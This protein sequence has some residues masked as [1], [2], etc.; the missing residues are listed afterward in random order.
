MKLNVVLAAF[1]ST[2]VVPVAA[3]TARRNS[4][5]VGKERPVMKVVRMLQDMN[6]ELT[7]AK[8][9]DD[10]V[11]QELTCWCNGGTAEKQ[12]AIELGEAKMDDLKAAM[13]EYGAKI[14]E[15]REGLATVKAKLREDKAAL[16]TATAI[17]MKE[18]KA[19]H[20]EE[21]DML[22]AIQSCG[23]ALVVLGKHHSLAQ[24][25]DVGKNL[26]ALTAMQLAK[27]NLGRDKMAVLKAFLQEAEDSSTG[28]LRRIPGMQSYTPASGQIVG[29]LKQMKEDFEADLSSSQK[30]EATSQSEFAQLKVAKQEELAAGKAQQ[31]QL[32]QDDAEFREKNAQA[33]EEYGDTE[34]QVATDKEF[35][36]NL[37][38]RCASADADYAARTKGRLA[39][40][41]AV[42]D[43][44]AFLN[45][46]EA[47]GSFDKTVNSAFLQTSSLTVSAKNLLEARRHAAQVLRRS[48]NAQLA[49]LASSVQIDAFEKVKVAI[50]NMVKELGKQQKEEVEHR[51]FC[52]KEMNTNTRE[53]AAMYDKKAVLETTIAD[54]TKTV[55]ELAKDIEERT[56]AIATMQADMKRSSE[57]RESENAEF[58]EEVTNQRITQGILQKACDRMNQVYSDMKVSLE[59]DDAAPHIQT[60]GTH[61]DPGN[62]PARFDKYQ[63]SSGG[64]KVVQ[65]IEEI[66]ADSK[67]SE[68][69]AL[70]SEQDAQAAYENNMKDL[71]KSIIEYTRAINNNVENKAKAEQTLTAAK[72][73]LKSTMRELEGLNDVINSLHKQCDFVLRNF[74]ARQA[75]RAQ[76]MDALNE[77][78]AILSG[79][80]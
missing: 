32:E 45:S 69:D 59:Q 34:E 14:E 80:Q 73:D 55:E 52:T 22:E 53:T 3:V 17:R 23:N 68:N 41:E 33:Y 11:Y 66:I 37:K 7:A 48:G 16:D 46:D 51:D 60:S 20:G 72:A 36:R 26:Q 70:R 75:A 13:G 12:S 58:Q 38:E 39:E 49:M 28:S 18:N 44:I 4:D 29:I 79:A 24:L 2:S 77:A 42:A 35:L 9:T 1:W 65:M 54:T 27:D 5:G 63:Q 30:E 61:T 74:E 43:T 8:E 6:K 21:T 50:D 47:A 64:D 71:N 10:Q 31:D 62:G 56:K 57:V 15:L 40:L 78:K 67:N 19:F 25:Q 76:E